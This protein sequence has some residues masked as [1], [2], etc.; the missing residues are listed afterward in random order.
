MDHRSGLAIVARETRTAVSAMTGACFTFRLARRMRR[1][2]DPVSA[3][4]EVLG[5]VL[6]KPAERS[7]IEA[8]DG[9]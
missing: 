5:N 7:L 4:R 3:K 9:Y 1:A 6:G 2:V 8:A